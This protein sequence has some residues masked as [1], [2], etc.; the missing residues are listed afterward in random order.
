M[1]KLQRA[2]VGQFGSWGK[3]Y[4]LQARFSGPSRLESRLAANI[5]CP[6]SQTDP[7]LDPPGFPLSAFSRV[8]DVRYQTPPAQILTGAL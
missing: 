7:L 5:G 4:C 6:T 2:A 1:F 8:R 3:Q